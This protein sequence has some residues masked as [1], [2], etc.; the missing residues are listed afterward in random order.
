[1]DHSSLS[2]VHRVSVPVAI[3][4]SLL[5]VG[6]GTYGLLN[7]LAFSYTI[8]IP[9]NTSSPALPFISMI[10]ARNLT[11]GLTGLTL[12]DIGKRK[13]AGVGLM[14]GVKAAM[15]DAWV[16][17]KFGAKEGKALEHMI[18]GIVAGALGWALY[19]G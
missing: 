7:P 15:G 11:S 3:L 14:A 19:W 2:T 4:M 12:I 10:G 8:G 1:M 17:S 18:M 16:C 9:V 6:S 5:A 13:A